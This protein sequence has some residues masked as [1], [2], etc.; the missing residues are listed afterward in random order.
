M[1]DLSH[2]ANPT[3]DI[4]SSVPSLDLSAI[5]QFGISLVFVLFVIFV[6]SFIT[7][8]FA[9]RGQ[10]GPQLKII[11]KLNITPSASIAIIAVG[12]KHILIGQ[13]A[14]GI[15]MLDDEVPVVVD[16][17][18]MAKAGYFDDLLKAARHTK[19]SE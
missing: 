13:S 12:K 5:W 8:K 15:Q 18:L 14:A 3:L 19:T 2:K 17:S 10:G 9:K 7:K 16:D 1:V 6:L 4:G 11:E